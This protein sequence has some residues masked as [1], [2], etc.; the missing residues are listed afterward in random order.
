V[1]Y[2]RALRA[3]RP[4]G[5]GGEGW[6]RVVAKTDGSA[7]NPDS[8]SKTFG[9]TVERLGLP[10]IRLHDLR[11][12]FAT[13]ALAAGVHVRVVADRLGHSSPAITLAVYS[14]STPRLDRDAAEAVR[15]LVGKG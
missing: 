7:Y 1:E 13:L 8:I 12:T 3:S 9:R 2:L 5:I 14:H 4:R 15:R 6:V 10:P 11:H